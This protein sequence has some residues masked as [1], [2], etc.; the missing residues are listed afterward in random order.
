[1]EGAE[2]RL[3]ERDSKEAA[4][5]AAETSKPFTTEGTGEHRGREAVSEI[6]WFRAQEYARHT[7]GASLDTSGFG[8]LL[9]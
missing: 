8:Y 5:R 4:I 1:M 7:S 6:R 9:I 2:K 3:R